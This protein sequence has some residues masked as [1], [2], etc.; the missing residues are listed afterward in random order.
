MDLNRRPR[1]YECQSPLI[2][3]LYYSFYLSFKTTIR[4]TVEKVKTKDLKELRRIKLDSMY[5]TANTTTE[6]KGCSLVSKG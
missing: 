3:L 2:T 5:A 1:A 6:H 4:D